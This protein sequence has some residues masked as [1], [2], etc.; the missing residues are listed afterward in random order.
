MVR[1]AGSSAAV[2][3]IYEHNKV[4]ILTRKRK[5]LFS[6]ATA[7]LHNRHYCRVMEKLKPFISA[8][9]KFYKMKARGKL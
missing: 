9:R 6:M 1:T 2:V 5:K 3:K 8:G 7:G 4:G